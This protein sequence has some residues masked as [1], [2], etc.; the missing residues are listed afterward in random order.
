MHF[1]HFVSLGLEVRLV[2][3]K[4]DGTMAFEQALV[5][6]CAYSFSHLSGG[7]PVFLRG[8]CEST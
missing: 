1:W 6:K 5:N 3:E 7:N 8:H 4:M 2:A